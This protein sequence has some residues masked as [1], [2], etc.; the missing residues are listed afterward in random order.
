MGLSADKLQ[1]MTYK[2]C[3][4]Y[5]NWSGTTRVPAVVQ[6]AHKLADLVGQYIH[7]TPSNLLEKQ[8]YFL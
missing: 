4:L 8:L 5:Y 1:I 2:M 7:Q 6:Y 3:H